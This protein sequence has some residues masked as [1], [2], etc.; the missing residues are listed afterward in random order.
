MEPYLK[1]FTY[2]VCTDQEKNAYKIYTATKLNEN[3]FSCRY[4]RIGSSSM[5]KDD[6]DLRKWKK[7]YFEEISDAK[8]YVDLTEYF[9][10]NIKSNFNSESSLKVVDKKTDLLNY[11][12]NCSST[13]I[14]ENYVLDDTIYPNDKLISKVQTL[15]NEINNKLK[16]DCDIKEINNIYIQLLSLSQR[17]LK[18][19]KSALFTEIKDDKEL[20]SS[21]E[22]MKEEQDLLDT[23]QGQIQ[24]FELNKT[25]LN[26]DSDIKQEI[27]FGFELIDISKDEEKKLIELL[28]YGDTKVGYRF[29]QAFKVINKKQDSIYNSVSLNSSNKKLLY[30]G[31]RNSNYLS[32]LKNSLKIRPQGAG[33]SGSLFGDGVYLSNSA[34]KSL[35]YTDSGRYFNGKSDRLFLTMFESELGN[36]YHIKKGER[37]DSSIDIVSYVKKNGF[38]STYAHAGLLYNSWSGNPLLRDEMIVYNDRQI[39]PKYIIELKIK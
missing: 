4:G 14:K 38:D 36:I 18:N 27:D 5:G 11:L 21:F 15:I 33:Y 35:G 39:T 29:M 19:V 2:L 28:N 12:M 37:Y 31:S 16:I 26:S 7:K 25:K 24:Q 23:L 32:I 20:Q 34:D 3:L 6:K 17:K 13:S 1:D 30:H 10:L 9:Q 22:K 8:K